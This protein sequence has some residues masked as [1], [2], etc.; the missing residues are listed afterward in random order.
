MTDEDGGRQ[1]LQPLGW[2]VE[3]HNTIQPASAADYAHWFGHDRFAHDPF[4][5]F[6]TLTFDAPVSEETA[7]R[8]FEGPFVNAL[9]DRARCRIEYVGAVE[10]GGAG[11]RVHIHAALARTRHLDVR[12]IEEAWKHGWKAVR[13]FDPA[14]GG[15]H[16]LAK[17]LPD[18]TA[19]LL[20]RPRRSK[21]RRGRRRRTGV[22][23]P[24]AP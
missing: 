10:H 6:V 20:L 4:D 9:D 21:T 18:G 8:L 11:E 13:V 3:D 22:S 7:K 2:M 16:Y 5:H 24:G 23:L 1:K 17:N 12:A 14:R 15:L 19:D